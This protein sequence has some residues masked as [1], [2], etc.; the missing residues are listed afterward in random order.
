[1]NQR[2]ADVAESFTR[3][4]DRVIGLA[5]DLVLIGGDVFHTVRPTNLAILHAFPQVSRLV[6]GLPGAIVA[7]VPGNHD[8][9]RST[10]TTCILRLFTPLGIH[11]V[12]RRRM[13]VVS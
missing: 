10:E 2:E 6:P 13:Q 4:V 5:P 1:M 7:M 11:V 8:M 12:K 3:A 9:P